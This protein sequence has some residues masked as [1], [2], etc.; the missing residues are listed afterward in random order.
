MYRFLLFLSLIALPVGASRALPEA[1]ADDALLPDSLRIVVLG[2]STAAGA[3]A[4]TKDSA[5]VWRYRQ[6][7]S[8]INPAYEVINLA[9][10]GYTSYH[11]QPSGYT[12]PSG[13]P[14]P[15]TLHNISTALSLNPSAV[16]INLPS[17]DAASNFTILEQSDNFERIA[18]EAAF[19]F[20]P[21]WVCTTQP[22]NLT[23]AKQQ[24][25]ITMRDW[26][27]NRFADFT[28]DF[29]TDLALEDGSM[30]PVFNAGDG[31]HLN[32]D[33]HALLFSRVRDAAIPEHLDQ[34][35]W[36]AA[37]APA[38]LDISVYPNPSRDA[39][40][41]R[42]RMERA[43][44][45]RIAVQDMLGRTVISEHERF[46]PAGDV[47][48]RLDLSALPAGMYVCLVQSPAG[49]ALHRLLISR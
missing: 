8:D 31:V 23:E 6:W 37:A 38:A 43:G 45:L 25:L 44:T 42:L 34:T 28:L 2:S 24:N 48:T 30:N 17:N 5:W 41:L 46:A 33:G 19:S 13:R 26:I 1:I 14:E 35:G 11:L 36:I 12:A 27:R 39:A 20:V 9:V 18:Q 40:T 22:R 15:D 47:F 32:D 49:P 7:L 16:I 21:I 10:G 29:W 3:G 4:S